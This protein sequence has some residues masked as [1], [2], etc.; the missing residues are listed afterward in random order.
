MYRRHYNNCGNNRNR[1]ANG[2]PRTVRCSMGVWAEKLK[3]L[4]IWMMAIGFVLVVVFIP[5]WFWLGLLGILLVLA[6]FA[7]WRFL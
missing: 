5:A 2:A 6:G 1:C 4:G 7:L 3:I